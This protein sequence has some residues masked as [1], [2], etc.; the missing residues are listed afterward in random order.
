[1]LQNHEKYFL[2]LFWTFLGLFRTFFGPIW[3][4]LGLSLIYLGHS[5]SCFNNVVFFND[6]KCFKIMGYIFGPFLDLFEPFFGPILTVLGLSSIYLG[7]SRSCFNNV[8]FFNDPKCFK[9]MEYIFG[10]ILDLFWIYFEP[11]LDLFGP[12][13]AYL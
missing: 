1:M 12:F 7:H 5:R 13:W 9:I 4:V 3:T 6:P 2:D 11:I 10:P 8:V